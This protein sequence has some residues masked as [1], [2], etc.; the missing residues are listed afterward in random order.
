MCL[1][2]E[3]PTTLRPEQEIIGYV[4]MIADW[5]CGGRFESMFADHIET[6]YVKDKWYT[7][8]CRPDRRKIYSYM[9]GNFDDATLVPPGFHAYF[10][11]RDAGCDAVGAFTVVEARFRGVIA[12]GITEGVFRCRAF[13]AMERKII[14]VVREPGLNPV[15]SYH[16]KLPLTMPWR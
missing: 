16:N 12:E 11:E 7:A 14:R 9:Y 2:N 4:C 5:A 6:L 10:T 15:E 3:R 1:I 8:T 13:R